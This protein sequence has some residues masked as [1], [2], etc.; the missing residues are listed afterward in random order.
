MVLSAVLQQKT[1]DITYIVDGGRVGSAEG[2]G[3]AGGPTGPLVF[4]LVGLWYHSTKSNRAFKYKLINWP[5]SSGEDTVFGQ[6]SE[7]L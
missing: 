4:P 7:L 3:A 6:N 1:S 2:G 5:I